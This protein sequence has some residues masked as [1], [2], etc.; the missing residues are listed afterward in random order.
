MFHVKHPSSQL[1]SME[2]E[3]RVRSIPPGQRP[4]DEHP[5]TRT[6]ICVPSATNHHRAFHDVAYAEEGIAWAR[7]PCHRQG[8]SVAEWAWLSPPTSSLLDR[9]NS[10]KSDHS[11]I[12]RSALQSEL[13]EELLIPTV[14]GWGFA[15]HDDPAKPNAP[16]RRA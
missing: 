11:R 13:V 4:M 2:A 10:N 12:R 15:N 1:T 8:L 14:T 7:S 16:H 5:R 6:N 9:V 3:S